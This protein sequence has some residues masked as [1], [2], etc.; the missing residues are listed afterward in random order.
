MKKFSS[1]WLIVSLFVLPC[2]LNM[3]NGWCCLII[4]ANLIGSFLM[5]RRHNPEYINQ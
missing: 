4:I 2:V 5:F 3:E 1:V